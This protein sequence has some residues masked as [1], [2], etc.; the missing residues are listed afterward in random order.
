ML[1]QLAKGA[2]PADLVG[3]LS[4]VVILPSEGREN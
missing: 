2:S 3:G 1:G 4:R